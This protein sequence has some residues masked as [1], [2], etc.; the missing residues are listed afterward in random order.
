MTERK[1]GNSPCWKTLSQKSTFYIDN[2]IMQVEGINNFELHNSFKI[3]LQGVV[4]LF[5]KSLLSTKYLL[6]KFW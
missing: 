4:T 2:I 1:K 3:H 6:Q 5:Q